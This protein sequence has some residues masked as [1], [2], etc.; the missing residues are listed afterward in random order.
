MEERKSVGDLENT[1]TPQPELLTEMQVVDEI[2][3]DE[4]EP[5]FLKT[6]TEMLA[7]MK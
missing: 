7:E 1:P 5:I 2:Q 3:L 6:F 4:Q